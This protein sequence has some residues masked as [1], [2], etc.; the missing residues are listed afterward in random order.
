MDD[1]KVTLKIELMVVVA[2][3]AATLLWIE[4][5]NRIDAETSAGQALVVRA[6]SVCP[7]NENVPYGP[8]CI[9]FMEGKG[10][11]GP[12]LAEAAKAMPSVKATDRVDVKGPACPPHNENVPY[13]A[14]CLKFL[15]GWFWQAN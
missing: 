11:P 14:R 13:S 7:D 2:S 4:Q 9:V 10:S 5:G 15:S 3:I 1:T 12:I 8:G 6:A